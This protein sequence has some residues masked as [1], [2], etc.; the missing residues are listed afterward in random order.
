MRLK[1]TVLIACVVVL[2]P[3]GAGAIRYELFIDVETEED[4]YDLYVTGQI[5]EASFDALLFLYQSPVDLNRASR[6]DLYRLPNLDYDAVDRILSYREEAGRINSVIE[7][8]D[9]GILDARIADS[10]QAFV[11]LAV[12]ESPKRGVDGFVRTQL[13][14]TGRYDRLPPPAALQARFR[15][16]ARLDAGVVGALLRNRVG[17][18]RWDPHRGGLSVAP[19]TTRFVVPKAYIEWEDER[20]NVVAGTYRI[21]F[22]Q[23][24]TFD[25]TG[26]VTPN[27][28]LGDGEL[29]RGNELTLRCRRGRGELPASPCPDGRVLRATPDFS[30]TNRLTGVG[31]GVKRLPVGPGWLQGYIWASYQVHRIR[32]SEIALADCDDPRRDEDPRCSA[33]LVFV[34][35]RDPFAPSP[36]VPQATLPAAVAEALGGTHLSYFWSARRHIGLT[37]YGAVPRWRIAGVALDF[38]EHS[39]TPFGGTFGAVGLDAAF[40]FRRQDFFAEVSRSFDRQAGAGGGFAMLV[41]SVTTVD[42]GEVDLSARYYAARYANPYARPPSASDQYEGLAARDEAGVRARLALQLGPRLTFRLLADAWR[43]LSRGELGMRL[44]ARMDARLNAA[45][46]SAFWLEHQKRSGKVTL[47]AL[48]AFAPGRRIDVSC[49]LQHRSLH[50]A[51]SDTRRQHDLGLLLRLTA[52]PSKWARLRLRV[53]YDH[54]DLADRQRLSQVLW[55]SVDLAFRFRGRDMMRVRYDVRAHLDE[56]ASTEERAPN[57]EHWLWLEHVVRY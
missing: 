49:Q 31:A 45:W 50:A 57:P 42:A 40:G 25:V 6:Q 24:L 36:T 7:L 19:E 30:W 37:G 15:G 13:G 32:A 35:Q 53:G 26:Q 3:D 46:S 44:F 43:R 8:V 20:F 47:A 28:L 16:L 27:G 11:F 18:P 2:W 51:L 10:L 23:R 55:G 54:E 38:Q 5:S 48:I 4:L 9:T 52:L 56:R 33:P 12:F 14:W 21:G 41:R 29:R 1:G 34:R 39:R 22:G 17:R